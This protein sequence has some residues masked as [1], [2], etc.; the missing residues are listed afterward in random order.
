MQALLVSLSSINHLSGAVQ[1]ILTAF[2]LG[3]SEISGSRKGLSSGGAALARTPG[4]V[5]PLTRR[6]REILELMREPI[7][8]KEIAKQLSLSPQTVKRHSINLYGKLGVHRRWEAVAKA[9]TL[10]ILPLR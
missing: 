8:I 5:E 4:L 1:R 10:G 7:S 2:P 3:E 6:E 9:T